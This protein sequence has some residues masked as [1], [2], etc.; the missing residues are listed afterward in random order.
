MTILK[1]QKKAKWWLSS[2]RTAEERSRILEGGND[3]DYVKQGILQKRGARV[4]DAWNPRWVQLSEGDLQYAY[5]EETTQSR[6]TIIDTIPIAEI[7][8]RRAMTV[9]LTARIYYIACCFHLNSA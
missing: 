5:Y 1:K 8:V 6:G 9:L 4:G 2:G 3:R 7:E